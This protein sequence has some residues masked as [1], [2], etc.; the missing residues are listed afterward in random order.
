MQNTH[1]L[2]CVCVCGRGFPTVFT[3]KRARYVQRRGE[4]ATRETPQHGSEKR[5]TE[6]KQ[7]HFGDSRPRQNKI[8]FYRCCCC[9]GGALI[10]HSHGKHKRRTGRAHTHPLSLLRDR[11]KK[12]HSGARLTYLR[13][14]ALREKKPHAANF[15]PY[16]NKPKPTSRFQ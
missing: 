10:S 15:A 6:R 16:T 5:E 11:G 13:F 14:G 3:G 12:K 2:K 4:P 8:S 1:A 7:L 9:R